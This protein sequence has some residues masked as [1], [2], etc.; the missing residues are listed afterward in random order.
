MVHTSPN[1]IRVLDCECS[2]KLSVFPVP[3]LRRCV[4]QFDH[5][6]RLCDLRWQPKWLSGMDDCNCPGPLRRSARPF[7]PGVRDDEGPLCSSATPRHATTL[8]HQSAKMAGR[9]K[10]KKKKME[11]LKPVSSPRLSQACIWQLHAVSPGC[12][13]LR[14]FPVRCCYVSMMSSPVDFNFSPIGSM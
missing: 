2:F 6:G 11:T 8:L 9:G 13:C 12:R 1:S 14:S 5:P 10:K 4:S 3:W 7:G